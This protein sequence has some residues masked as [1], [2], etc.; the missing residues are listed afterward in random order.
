M[1]FS[2][3]LSLTLLTTGT[4]I[5]IL[6]TLV[7]YRANYNSMIQSQSQYTRAIASSIAYDIDLF[8]SEKIKINQTLANALNIKNALQ[9]SNLYYA[10]MSNEKRVQSIELNNR[11]WKSILDPAD[12]YILKYT[13]NIVARILKNQQTSLDG[14]YGEIFLT[15]KFGALVASTAK[16]STFAHG[17]KYWWRGAYKNGKG[18]IFFDD[19]GYDESVGG[20]VLGLVIPIRNGSEIIGIIK[21]NLNILGSIS[22][23][24]HG[25]ETKDEEILGKIKLTRSGGMIVFEDG[26]EPLSSQV[27]D[28]VFQRLKNR[29]SETL[30]FTNSQGEFFVGFAEVRST[31]GRSGYGFGGSFE[32]IDHKKGNTGESWYVICYRQL[33]TVR[34]PII[35]SIKTILFSGA[36]IV[37]LLA[38][39][40]YG[41]GRK[42]GQPLSLLDQATEKLGKGDFA[43][44]IDM[45]RNDEFGKLSD[46][47]NSMA[48]SLQQTTTSIEQLQKEIEKRTE[49]EQQA[50]YSN[51]LLQCIDKLR[52]QFIKEPDPF[53]LFPQLL[54]QLL[55]LTNSEYG[56]VGDV[57]KDES[58]SPYLKLYGL[59]NL[60]WNEETDKLY[61]E[62][63][64]QG[65][66]FR[67]LD[68]LFGLV[69][70]S[71][72][73]VFS[74]GPAN[75]TRRAGLPEGHPALSSF[76]GIPVYYGERLVGEVGL[77]NRPG[78][79]DQALLDSISPVIA[80]LGQII[81]DRWDRTARQKGEQ[82]IIEAKEAAEVAN[83]S[84]S[85]FLANMSHEIRTPLNA[86]VGMADLLQEAV[87][88]PD[89][90]QYLNILDTSS[91]TL[92]NLVNDIIDISRVEAGQIKLEHIDFSVA[93]LLE[94]ISEM[95]AL[96]AHQKQLELHTVL[97]PDL[98]LFLK[99]DFSRLRQILVNLISN[100]IKFTEKG[101]I[102][103][104]CGRYATHGPHPTDPESLADF[105]PSDKDGDIDVFF[106]V[107]DSGI[108]ISED[109]LSVI[110]ERFQQADMSSTR[111]YGGSGLG[112]AISR[113]LVKLMQGA[114][115]AESRVG[116][117]SVF[118]FI[119]KMKKSDKPDATVSKESSFTPQL[120][121]KSEGKEV[122]GMKET[123][124]LQILLVDDYLPNRIIV[125]QYLKNTPF[126]LENAEDGAVAVEKFKSGAYDLVLM[127]LQMPVMD[128][129]QATREIKAFEKKQNRPPVP[130]IAI[131][132]YV[133]ENDIKKSRDAG[134]IEHINKPVEKSHLLSLLAKYAQRAPQREEVQPVETNK[135]KAENQK[136]LL[137]L[138]EDFAEFIPGF[139]KNVKADVAV[140]Q[141][142]L[143]KSDF[144]LIC[145]TS[146]RI[147]GA[148]G[149][150]GLN[151]ISEIAQLVE[152]AARDGNEAE[153]DKQL[154]KFANY[155]RLLEIRFG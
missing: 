132:A 120:S 101:K 94:G 3:K 39:L 77:A 71:G 21:C 76:L 103:I 155:L 57:L 30:I 104:S 11:K 40:S 119:V 18:A 111:E 29:N 4:S 127:D 61:E 6:I 1:K 121:G 151:E 130:V 27:D 23:L 49:A 146:H 22:D 97:E 139:I 66:E 65:L 147:K 67:K 42:I 56:L 60:A 70:T 135:Y 5:L 82:E 143:L 9:A 59:S 16:L 31:T 74:D 128:G 45:V 58:G 36:A 95:M 134:C 7:I 133:M 12:D 150:Y 98:P 85:V 2:N 41:F 125:Q 86:I 100:A 73:P 99:G 55:K 78:G 123:Q 152:I 93:E 80:A 19:R 124:P 8:L 137:C 44:R 105:H 62:Y 13:D 142:A 52:Q 91:E 26:F 69:V 63:R 54:E 35:E 28:A 20:Y 136:I 37:V 88:S 24:I 32:S 10:G 140:M 149:G 114:I 48:G 46:S 90:Q 138:E 38:L 25:H 106:S 34:A 131:S 118:N 50:L 81:V 14:E 115:W 153:T 79:Y 154:E 109:N 148:G 116:E 72:K 53:L 17:H 108:G 15:N 129:F 113:S 96:K 117:G 84:K 107:S 43:Y 126:Q 64:Q 144:T 47:F 51:Q 92:Q 33:E 145:Q 110:F 83:R 112:L 75:D 141:D 68:N 87:T 122:P 102:V 89:H